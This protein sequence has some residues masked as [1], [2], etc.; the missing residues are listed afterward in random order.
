MA[1][2]KNLPEL[3]RLMG[4]L[5]LMFPKPAGLAH[6]EWSIRLN[7]LM[8]HV[9]RQGGVG[10]PAEYKELVID[11]FRQQAVHPYRV[12]A[13]LYVHFR[14]LNSVDSPKGMMR[15]TSRDHADKVTAM[16][17]G[18]KSTQGA[19]SE[20]KNLARERSKYASISHYWAALAAIAGGSVDKSSYYRRPKDVLDAFLIRLGLDNSKDVNRFWDNPKIEQ[21]IRLARLFEAFN[22]DFEQDR[23]PERWFDSRR[24]VAVDHTDAVWNL[25]D[26]ESLLKAE[27]DLTGATSGRAI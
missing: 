8:D 16:V 13:S 5:R 18:A 6:H 12:G 10:V 1:D 9:G 26:S 21:F 3:M 7:I 19:M 4:Y 17:L 27:A 15:S 22:A 25:I 14:L 23:S 24:Q 20:A 11:K 2:A